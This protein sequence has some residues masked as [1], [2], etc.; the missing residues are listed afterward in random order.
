MKVLKYL[1]PM[2]LLAIVANAQE[3]SEGT[4]GGSGVAAEIVR[5]TNTF[6]K[7][8]ENNPDL[9]VGIDPVKLRSIKAQILVTGHAIQI[10]KNQGELEAWSD[11]QSNY[12]KFSLPAWLG[13]DELSKIQ[14]VG[15]ERLVLA[16]YEAS[17]TYD[18]SN[19]IYDVETRKLESLYRDAPEICSFGKE[20][21]AGKIELEKQI[22]QIVRVSGKLTAYG[23]LKL[24]RR[25]NEIIDIQADAT[26]LNSA[27]YHNKKRFEAYNAQVHLAYNKHFGPIL[28]DAR[29]LITQDY[30]SAEVAACVSMVKLNNVNK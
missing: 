16:G 12:S 6:I 20:A 3:G 14:L 23:C 10:C 24:L 8:V 9:F 27:E 21:C 13:K 26:A 7:A 19:K 1:L 5:A 22:A 2:L 18:F 29:K 15:H 4:G 11:V 25:V 30:Q 17:N 28:N